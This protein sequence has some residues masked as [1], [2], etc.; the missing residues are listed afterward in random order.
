MVHYCY[1]QAT[2]SLTS[3]VVLCHVVGV[4]STDLLCALFKV[5]MTDTATIENTREILR[6]IN[7]EAERKRNRKC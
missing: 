7:D 5:F 1:L 6:G 4:K 3:S 2:Y